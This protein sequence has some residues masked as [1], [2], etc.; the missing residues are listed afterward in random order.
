MLYEFFRPVN[1]FVL[2]D[3][4]KNIIGRKNSW[5]CMI[6]FVLWIFSSFRP[7]RKNSRQ[8][9]YEFFRLRSMDEK[10]H[11]AKNFMTVYEF[12]RPMNFFVF[13]QWKKKFIGRKNSYPVMKFFVLWIFSSIDP[14]RKNS[15]DEKIHTT[16]ATIS[17][18]GD[19]AL[20]L[21]LKVAMISSR[22]IFRSKSKEN[23]KYLM[24][25]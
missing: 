2:G 7:R 25:P 16:A 17:V 8:S 24:F 10:I 9:V 14:R 22:D 13:G 5:P 12:F 21:S 18:I 11:R 4:T 6:I 1:F 19:V 3:R 23:K 15:R 20:F